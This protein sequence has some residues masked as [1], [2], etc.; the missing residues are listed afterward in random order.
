VPLSVVQMY[1]RHASQLPRPVPVL[2]QDVPARGL[3]GPS[4]LQN[5]TLNQPGSPR[6]HPEPS[7]GRQKKK[8]KKKKKERKEEENQTKR[9]NYHKF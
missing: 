4:L 5:T 2:A 8:K 7:R 9:A 6:Q 1:P 3:H